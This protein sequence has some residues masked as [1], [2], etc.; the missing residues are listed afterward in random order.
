MGRQS[1]DHLLP[2]SAGTPAK[3]SSRRE[4]SHSPVKLA[5]FLGALLATILFFHCFYG[6]GAGQ[7]SGYVLQELDEEILDETDYRGRALQIL[8]RVPLIDGHNDLPLHLAYSGPL[9]NL[10]LTSMPN[11]HTDL[12]RIRSGRLGGQFWSGYVPCHT[13]YTARDDSV[14][15][16]LE[17]IDLIHRF[18]K[19]APDVLEFATTASDIRRI[20]KHGKVASLIGL[21]GA[22]QM[23]ASLGALRMYYELGVRYMTLTHTCHSAWADSCAPPPLHN[24]LTAF[25]ERAVLEMNRLG[26]LV[27]LSHVSWAT[28]RSVLAITKAPVFFSHSS[29]HSICK[30]TRNVPDEILS[31]IH[32]TDGVV[33]VNFYPGFVSCGTEST[34]SVVADHIEHIAKVAGVEHVGIGSDFDGIDA[35]PVGLEDVGKYPDLIVELLRRGFTVKEVEGIVG[36]NALRVMEG[37]EKVAKEMKREGYMPVEDR[38]VVNKTCG[39]VL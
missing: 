4:S 26:M 16:T 32:E 7:P 12:E 34:L 2:S 31:R 17:Q 14:R 13:P 6:A 24:G 23:D 30:I 8:K 9:A 1:T 28:M 10:N 18:V 35:V 11:R 38:L 21:E 36:E 33:M 15:A 3:Q 25:G 37:V 39:V 5:C 20:H 29:A 19:A 27:D 22:H